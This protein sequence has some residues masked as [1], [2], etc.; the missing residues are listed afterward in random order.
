MMA[1]SLR[2]T[3]KA[4]LT[5]GAASDTLKPGGGDA[6]KKIE[7]EVD[8]TGAAVVSADAPKKDYTKPVSKVPAR[9]ADKASASEPTKK[10]TSANI[11]ETDE[12]EVE[13]EAPADEPVVTEVTEEEAVEPSPRDTF[14]FEVDVKEDMDAMFNGSDLSEEFKTKA[15]AIFEAA[16]KTNLKK[17]K[18]VLDEEYD[19]TVAEAVN[20]IA[21]EMET[22][23]EKYLDYVAEGWMSENEVAIESSLRTELTE[24]FISGLRNLFMEN[25]IDIPE[26]KVPVVEEMSA[27]VD[28]LETK[29]NEEIKKNVDLK[30][31]INESKKVAAVAT[32]IAAVT[33]GLTDTQAE[34]IKTLAEATEFTT[35]EEYT[36]KVKALK[37]SYFP[38]KTV[39]KDNSLIVEV[40]DSPETPIVEETL[41]GPMAAYAKAISKSRPN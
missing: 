12:E 23:V 19:V 13:A 33:E 35:E 30:A 38:S 15:T 7:G 24:D 25:F 20:V 21:E 1:K 29:L 41:E 16:L 17:Y 5:E 4:L 39:K 40:S 27:K 6:P 3:V 18:A 22:K 31:S 32:V 28:E 26:D 8:D 11:K 9:P 34:K 2:D 36:E 10:L 14:E 37:E